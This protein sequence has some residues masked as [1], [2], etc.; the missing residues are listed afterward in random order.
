MRGVYFVATLL[1]LLGTSGLAQT[2]KVY[3]PKV[4]AASLPTLVFLHGGAWVGGDLSQYEDGAQAYNSKG[5]RV[6]LANYR[7]APN[8]KHPVPVDD[9]DAILKKLPATYSQIYLAGHSAGAHLIAFWNT[10]HTDA[11]V[12]GLIGIEGIYDISKLVKVWPSYRGSFISAEFGPDAS[13]WAAA[14]PAILPAKSKIAWLLIHSE[15][16]EL[17]DLA[18]T[19]DFQK[20]LLS[21]KIPVELMQL[22]TESHFGAVENFGQAGSP[23]FLKTLSFIQ[24]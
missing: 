19:T 1:L 13:K 16:D 14:S 3:E 5:V 10:A 21:Q 8:F 11:R 20:H 6:V 24:H 9:L 2:F 12:R 18:Q 7:L 23:V 4:S 15:K 22:K 17:V